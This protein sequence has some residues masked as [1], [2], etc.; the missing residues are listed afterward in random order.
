MI[1]SFWVAYH[2]TAI[3]GHVKLA[4]LLA[5]SSDI[6]IH[7]LTKLSKGKRSDTQINKSNVDSG[8]QLY[9]HCRRATFT[10]LSS[11][12]FQQIEKVGNASNFCII[13]W[14]VQNN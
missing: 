11:V 6:Q 8:I 9:G 3:L 12:F 14:P 13:F 1:S 5:N 2:F 10:F 4:T 7:V